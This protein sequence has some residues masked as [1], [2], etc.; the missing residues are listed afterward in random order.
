MAWDR[1]PLPGTPLSK[2]VIGM[3][4]KWIASGIDGTVRSHSQWLALDGSPPLFEHITVI[5]CIYQFCKFLNLSVTKRENLRLQ[6]S[7]RAKIASKM[8]EPTSFWPPVEMSRKV[9]GC[10]PNTS[11][12]R[13]VCMSVSERLRA[14][15]GKN[16]TLFG[17][18]GPDSDG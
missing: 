17:I 9:T 4:L 1:K 14:Q 3:K 11:N 7:C 6:E 8:T 12:A 18:S 15:R 10:E 2:E 16:P 13:G 5:P